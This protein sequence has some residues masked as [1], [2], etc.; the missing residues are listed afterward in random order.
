M[1]FPLSDQRFAQKRSD[2][3]TYR[4]PRLK[5]DL[6]VAGPIDVDFWITTT[7]TDADLVVKVI[8]GFP[9]GGGALA[10]DEEMVRADVFR[11]K[12]RDSFENPSPMKPGVPT[13]VHFKLNDVLH[14]F[15]KGHHLIVQVQSS[16]FP[17]V[18]RNP[19]TFEDIYTAKD[20]DFQKATI[21]VLHDPSH[22]TSVGLGVLGG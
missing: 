12:F 20:S 10:G 8:D 22:P 3:L 15:L 5:D 11:C 13:H 18:D 1:E 16:W 4:A 7:G 14:S 17:L 9:D 21:S 2:V 19:N 6:N